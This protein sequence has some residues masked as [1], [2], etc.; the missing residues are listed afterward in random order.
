M[1]IAGYRLPAGVTVIPAIGLVHSSAAVYDDP[2]AFRPDRML[3]AALTPT[4]W[5]PFGGGNR[6]CLGATLALTELRV[7]LRA[8]LRGATLCT[9][10]N[11]GERRRVRGVIHQ[12]HRGARI[13]VTARRKVC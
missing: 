3:G 8:V 1:E 12:P 2:D 9:T 10:E 11:P 5:L 6:R 13:R 4:T 7:I